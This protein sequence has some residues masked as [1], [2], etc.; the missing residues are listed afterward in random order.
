MGTYGRDY[1]TLLDADTVFPKFYYSLLVHTRYSDKITKYEVDVARDGAVSSLQLAA[2]E[3]T[4]GTK[5]FLWKPQVARV[6]SLY[7]LHTTIFYWGFAF[8]VR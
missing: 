5:I 3:P 4:I 1:Q 7:S 8:P 2:F 6:H